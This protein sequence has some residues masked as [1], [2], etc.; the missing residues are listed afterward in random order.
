M[1][2]FPFVPTPPT[3]L[4]EEEESSAKAS[5]AGSVSLSQVSLDSIVFLFQL[6]MALA[7]TNGAY[8]FLTAASAAYK[9]RP[10]DSYTVF[11]TAA[12]FVF[13]ATLIPF[14]HANV[15]ILKQGYGSGFK[16]RGIQP[17]VDFVLLFVESGIFYILSFALATIDEDMLQYFSITGVILAIDVLWALLTFSFDRRHKVVLIY[18]LLN[19]CTV[20]A[21]TVEILLD[22]PHLRWALLGTVLVRTS[23]DY[24]LTYNL[25]F[26]GAFSAIGQS[27]RSQGALGAIRGVGLISLLLIGSALF[28]PALSGTSCQGNCASLQLVLVPVLVVGSLMAAVAW[29]LCVVRAL[30]AQQWPWFTALLILTPAIPIFAILLDSGLSVASH[31][32]LGAWHDVVVSTLFSLSPLVGL[33]YGFSSR[34][35]TVGAAEVAEVRSRSR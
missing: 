1:P 32:W 22:A 30:H 10:W 31:G 13:V 18:A 5:A 9:L 11:G 26:P 24:G 29:V 33:L 6:L 34:Q 21:G 16:D 25:L 35:Q 14:V 12:F 4:D 27:T 8:I 20:A 17:F 19:R 3:L 7:L 2:R 28:I 23:L 15:I